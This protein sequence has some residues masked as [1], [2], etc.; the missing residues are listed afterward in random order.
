MA[1]ILF[2]VRHCKRDPDRVI[3]SIGRRAEVYEKRR[4]ANR[5]LEVF[6]RRNCIAGQVLRCVD[7]AFCEPAPDGV[8]QGYTLG[9]AV[10]VGTECFIYHTT[11]MRPSRKMGP[12][13]ENLAGYSQEN[14]DLVVRGLG[15]VQKGAAAGFLPGC[16]RSPEN[17]DDTGERGTNAAD[18]RRSPCVHVR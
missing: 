1:D 10:E 4:A 5:A 9:A 6:G 16:R 13:M 3:R 7:R 8:I 12:R 14:S 11:S 18:S 17:R 15:E 2:Y